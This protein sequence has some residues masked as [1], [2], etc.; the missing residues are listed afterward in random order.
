MNKKTLAQAIAI[1][2]G[3]ILGAIAF[4]MACKM[5]PIIGFIILFGGMAVIAITMLY[6]LVM[7]VYDQIEY[8]K[9][10]KYKKFKG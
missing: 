3:I 2:T 9:K 5:F 8:N 6:M 1:I 4:V 7:A 10:Y